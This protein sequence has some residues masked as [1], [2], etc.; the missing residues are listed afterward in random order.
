MLL[1][2][3]AQWLREAE[4]LKPRN[5]PRLRLLA[6]VA[7]ESKAR[8]LY[9]FARSHYDTQAVAWIAAGL[10]ITFHGISRDGFPTNS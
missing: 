4:T 5:R 3:H 9:L 7:G 1:L 8:C 6:D 2:H 10:S